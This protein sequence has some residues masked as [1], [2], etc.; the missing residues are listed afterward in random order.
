MG[1]L[2]ILR[3][4]LWCFYSI[5]A[6]VLVSLNVEGS[7]V[8]APNAIRLVDQRKSEISANRQDFQKISSNCNSH[9]MILRRREWDLN[10]RGPEGP[11]ACLRGKM[12]TMSFL[13]LKACALSTLPSGCKTCVSS[14]SRHIVP[15]PMN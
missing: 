1:H 11:Q 12:R 13:R 15:A 3:V 2:G 5:Y 7:C 10:P 9:L 6:F 4:T 8:R 14:L